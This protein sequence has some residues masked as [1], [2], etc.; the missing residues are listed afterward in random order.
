MFDLSLI[1]RL[2]SAPESLWVAWVK[3]TL[4]RNES[5]WIAPNNTQGSRIWRKLLKL[6][7]FTSPFIQGIV[8]NGQTISFWHENWLSLGKLIDIIGDAGPR[9]LVIPLNATVSDASTPTGWRI[10]RTRMRHLDT[11]LEH[12]RAHPIPNAANGP[13]FYLWRIEAGSY[14][15]RISSPHTWNQLRIHHPPVQWW[16][17]LWFNHG[18]PR[19]RFITWLAIRNR[20]STGVRMRRWG[21][22]QACVLCGERD[23][24]RDHLFFACPYSFTVWS[25]LAGRLL[26]NRQTPDWTDTVN[27]IQT[28]QGDRLDT[29]LIR[30]VFQVTVYYLW[31]EQNSRIH[32]SGFYSASQLVRLID[33]VVR[34]RITS[35]QYHTDPKLHLLMQR[36]FTVAP[37]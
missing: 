2:F 37:P 12:I 25:D 4:L 19:C 36:W 16:R 1:W 33:K 6:R 32:R 7:I 5:F 18:I 22:D 3:R 10:R 17:L 34:N 8:R 9:L 26:R 30:L 28:F 35:L 13:D 15:D 11:V 31:R 27:S 29:I 23:E 21:A 24:S 20:L 14:K